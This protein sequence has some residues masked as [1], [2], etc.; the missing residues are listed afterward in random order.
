LAATPSEATTE[1]VETLNYAGMASSSQGICAP[2][3]LGCKRLRAPSAATAL[4]QR[5][6]RNR[7]GVAGFR[8]EFGGGVED[9]V[10]QRLTEAARRADPG[11]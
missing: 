8:H 4:G 3:R 11:Y 9:L 2:R 5:A 7:F 6:D 10:V 1:R